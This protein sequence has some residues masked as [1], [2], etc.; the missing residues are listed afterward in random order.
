MKRFPWNFVKYKPETSD[1]QDRHSCISR[2][3]FWSFYTHP[4]RPSGPNS[5]C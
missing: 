5:E 1:L 4:L 3:K 2:F